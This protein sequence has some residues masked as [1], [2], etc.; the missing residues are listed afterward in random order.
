MINKFKNI[1]K[2]HR[3]ASRLGGFTPV[4]LVSFI[5]ITGVGVAN[6]NVVLLANGDNSSIK[7]MH[8]R[9]VPT[10]HESA[11]GLQQN[12]LRPVQLAQSGNRSKSD[13]MS[14]VKRRY[15]GA[16]IL[17]IKLDSSSN[18]YRVRILLP[19]GKVRNVTV[20]AQK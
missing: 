3:K 5:F 11:I 12:Q 17:R 19:S 10:K 13:A 6:A 9:A 16:K 7:L 14:E 4:F 18:K 15:K 20:S 2:K 1:F 8:D